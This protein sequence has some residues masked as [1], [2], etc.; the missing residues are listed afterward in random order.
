M[1]AHTG[2]SGSAGTRRRL[3][4][5]LVAVASV[6]ALA[7]GGAAAGGPTR[8]TRP[9]AALGSITIGGVFC[10]CHTDVYV[11]WKKDF[12]AKHGVE[13]KSYVLTQGGS[14]TIAGV[15]GGT[16]DFG[17][18]TLEAV[19]RSQA[20]SVPLKAV[21]NLYPE[22]WS[23]LVRNDQRSTIRKISDLKGKTVGVSLIGS[24]SWAFLVGMLGKAGINASDVNIVQLGG[25]TNI[26]T[27]LKAKKVDAS[28]AWEPGTSAAARGGIATPIVNLQIPG[29]VGKVFGSNVSMSQVLAVRADRVSSDPALVKAVVAA[30]K[31]ADTWLIANKKH[32]VAVANVLKSVAP[33]TISTGTLLAAVKAA[34]KVQPKTP[35]LTRQGYQTSTSLLV[36]T[37]ALKQPVPFD[38]V[39]DC[40]FAGCG[41]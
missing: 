25:L 31:D 41:P 13:V 30:I 1:R 2:R 6:A 22:F 28:I 18:T 10:T 3:M 14:A 38:Q 21:A 17:P 20:S 35:L 33:G 9:V 36:Q 19:V 15:A 39:V 27:A 11:A 34:L 23:L 12:L 8:S 32:P 37:G 4:V 29:V 40:R 24:G 7:L 16:F 26:L 5:A